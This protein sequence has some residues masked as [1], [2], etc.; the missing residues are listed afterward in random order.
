MEENRRPR[1]RTIKRT[2]TANEKHA[3]NMLPKKVAQN[4]Y[5]KGGD[6]KRTHKTSEKSVQKTRENGELK[7]AP[8][9]ALKNAPKTRPGIQAVKE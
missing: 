6:K 3:P 7:S 5:K 8:K 1:K 4:C 2:K 9:N